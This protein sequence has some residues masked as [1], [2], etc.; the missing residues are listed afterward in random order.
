MSGALHLIKLAVGVSE[1]AELEAWVAARAAD[2]VAR[3]APPH[4]WH[5]TRMRPTRAEALLAGG[6]LYWV[7]AG[8][9]RARQTL[10]AME[11]AT[12]DAGQNATRL[13]LAPTIVRVAPRPRRPFQGW[14]YL[15]QDEAPPDLGAGAGSFAS[16]GE[17]APPPEL[18]A[19]LSEVGVA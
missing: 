10:L 1:V 9:I 8:A 17:D 13:V 3:G 7:I 5:T 12:N 14:R 6:S 15:P 11:D 16:H 19:A 18:M 2:C 4:S